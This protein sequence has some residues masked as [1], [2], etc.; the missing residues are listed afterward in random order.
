MFSHAPLRYWGLRAVNVYMPKDRVTNQ[1]QGY[2]FVEFKGEEDADYVSG[3]AHAWAYGAV[4]CGE[5]GGEGW[6]G[7]TELETPSH[8]ESPFSAQQS[9]LY[10]TYGPL[11]LRG[12]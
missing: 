12:D 5:W 9:P 10:V 8:S 7:V 1:H 11:A 3:T 4:G 2:G 6:G